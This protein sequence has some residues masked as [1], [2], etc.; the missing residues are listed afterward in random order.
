MPGSNELDFDPDLPET[1]TSDED[2]DRLWEGLDR[3]EKSFGTL[4]TLLSILVGAVIGIFILGLVTLMTIEGNI[5][6]K[7]KALTI[8]ICSPV[9]YKDSNGW[10]TLMY[11][12][13]TEYHDSSH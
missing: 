10:Q 12:Q 2:M 11:N 4:K 3:V 13:C 1:G 8:T 6:E 7:P 9:S 5:P